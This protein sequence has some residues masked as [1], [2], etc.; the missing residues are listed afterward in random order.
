MKMVQISKDLAE[1]L[2]DDVNELLAM[3][4]G[5][6]SYSERCEK[7]C[8]AYEKEVSELEAAIVEGAKKAPQ[9]ALPLCDHQYHTYEVTECVK[10]GRELSRYSEGE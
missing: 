2:L 1:N 9:P 6:R 4:Q 7:R 8:K 3:N 5:L 10:C